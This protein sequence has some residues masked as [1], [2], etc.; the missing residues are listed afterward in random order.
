MIYELIEEKHQ[1]RRHCS[2]VLLMRT[3]LFLKFLR[4]YLR[5]GI[6]QKDV[7]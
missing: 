6:Y 3:M 1:N 7:P 5:H 2:E 4:T